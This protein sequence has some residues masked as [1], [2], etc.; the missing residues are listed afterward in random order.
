MAKVFGLVLGFLT[1]IFPYPSQ[2]RLSPVGVNNGQVITPELSNSIQEILDV[3]NITGLSV[4]IVPKSGEPEYHSW[5]DRTEDGES[6]TQ[7]S[8]WVA[9]WLNK[10]VHDNV[11]VIPSSVYGNASQSF[12]VSIGTPVDSEH[13]IEGYG[14]GWFR[15]SYLGHDVVYHSGSIRGLSTRVSFLPDNDVGVVVFANGD[16]KAA[17]VMNISNSII[18]AALHLRSGPA[19]P[20]IPEKKAVTSPSEDIVNLELPLE[21]FSGTYTDPGYGTFT[22]CSPSSDSLYCQ[23]VIANFTAVDSVRPSAPSS[24]QLLAAWPRVWTSHLRAVHQS[25]NKFMLLPTALFPEGYGRDSTPFETAEI[26]TPGATAEFVVENG[27][28]VGFGLFGGDQVAER[29]RTLTTVKDRAEVWFDKVQ[30]TG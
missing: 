9:L 14:L 16:N 19:P 8:K 7:D 17:P 2:V 20:I 4:A 11:T 22:F 24:P 13:S 21:E 28:V 1:Q 12:A 18:D 30:N 26:G 27:K 6:V 25:G 5:G 3:W 15:N 10:G 23:Q 29:A